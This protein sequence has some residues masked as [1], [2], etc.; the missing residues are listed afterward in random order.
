MP[1]PTWKASFLRRPRRLSSTGKP[2]SQT[3][4]NSATPLALAVLAQATAKHAVASF[5]ASEGVIRQT[6]NASH[7]GTLNQSVSNSGTISVVGTAL[8]NGKDF[9]KAIASMA[10]AAGEPVHA[11]NIAGVNQAVTSSGSLSLNLTAKA[12]GATAAAVSHN[13]GHGNTA[14]DLY[15]PG[16]ALPQLR[17]HRA[18]RG[19]QPDHYQY[20]LSSVTL[21]GRKPA[22]HGARNVE[23]IAGVHRRSWCHFTGVVLFE[24]QDRDGGAAVN[25]KFTN[26]GTITV[27]QSAKAKTSGATFGADAEI[28]FA[29]VHQDAAQS[30]DAGQVANLSI[31]N[32]GTLS[33]IQAGTATGAGAAQAGVFG[34]GLVQTAGSQSG[35]GVHVGATLS[36]NNSGTVTISNTA[37][38][39]GK[40]S[41]AAFADTIFARQMPVNNALSSLS[42]VNSGKVTLAA[43][44]TAAA[45][46]SAK[47]AGVIM[48]GM[49][50]D[51]SRNLTS[52]P[53]GTAALSM[54]NSGTLTL[55]ATAK[56]S[57]G[58]RA[59][60]EV[61]AT[62]AEQSTV[63][64][65]AVSFTNSGA[66]SVSAAG[67]L[68][69]VTPG[70]GTVAESFPSAARVRANRISV[71]CQGHQR[72]Q[73]C[74]NS[75]TTGTTP[76][77]PAPTI[78]VSNSGTMSV[79]AVLT[80]GGLLH[81][82]ASVAAAGLNISATS[83][84]FRKGTTSATGHVV[85]SSERWTGAPVH[86][87]ISNSGAL[88]VGA[89]GAG[90]MAHAQGISVGASVQAESVT[91][92]A[93]GAISVTASGATA[94]AAGVGLH[95]IFRTSRTVDF[96]N[97]HTTH[98]QS[99]DVSQNISGVGP[100]ASVTGN[101]SNSGTITVSAT[102][103]VSEKAD[104]IAV[105]A[106]SVS[107]TILNAGSI[108]VS[109]TG[110]GAIANGI[111]LYASKTATTFTSTEHVFNAATAH[112]ATHATVY[113]THHAHTHI[114]KLVT[115]SGTINNTGTLSVTATAAGS[116]A[117]ANGI[118]VRGWRHPDGG[119]RSLNAG[120][121]N[122]TPGS[123]ATATVN[124]ELLTDGSGAFTVLSD[125]GGKLN[126]T[127]TST[128]GACGG[129]RGQRSPMP[130][131]PDQASPAAAA[132]L[133][134]TAPM[135]PPPMAG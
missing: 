74:R 59:A 66:I 11:A 39:S 115:L 9:G 35:A 19:D 132:R 93:G 71:P 33:I 29:A 102:G 78:S 27:N 94:L 46:N 42:I 108:T 36:I 80:G 40:T 131:W 63:Q 18:D 76:R 38:A 123:G 106:A 90:N 86:G 24:Q 111:R 12:F 41:G 5:T 16:R 92:A 65:G 44:A 77:V 114:G 133:P 54:S 57:A 73:R 104:G 64:N 83:K 87:A 126:A 125:K 13:R 91:N 15:L 30:Q 55:T 43:A 97:H 118:A 129:Y 103:T 121:I 53:V 21:Q 56:A 100:S 8:A 99:N 34:A 32:S 4:T 85:N 51:D 109:A 31:V 1:R 134:P 26:S 60:V 17:H 95:N 117:A 81:A 110:P 124:D 37:K 69:T 49:F 112:G 128:T 68:A 135:A 22:C 70:A 62:A 28:L 50:Q 58:N 101:V 88:T 10:S 3:I 61:L 79:A 120:T 25:Q 45:T 122:A 96:H 113:G 130:P 20:R 47:A 82:E 14:A 84:V 67:T 105:N 7:N 48:E 89:T 75:G 72:R 107:D 98:F 119:P 127:A 2:I 52:L 23:A 6:A 116:A